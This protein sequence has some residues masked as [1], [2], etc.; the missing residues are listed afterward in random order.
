MVKFRILDSPI[1]LTVA[2][3]GLLLAETSIIV[4]SYIIAYVIK[5]SS[6]S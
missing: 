4:I 3:P 5:T 6:W 2:P 1:F